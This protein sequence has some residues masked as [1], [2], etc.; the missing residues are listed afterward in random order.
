VVVSSWWLEAHWGRAFEL[1]RHEPLR[2][3]GLEGLGLDTHELVLGRPRPEQLTVADLEREEPDEPREQRARVREVEDARDE[4]RAT[5]ARLEDLEGRHGRLVEMW[6]AAVAHGERLADEGVEREER[7]AYLEARVAELERRGGPD[8]SARA[9]VE[10]ERL[11]ARRQEKGERERELQELREEL[12]EHQSELAR[13][14]DALDVVRAS[15][16]WRLTAPLRARAA[17][18]R[19]R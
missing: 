4:L 11:A 8:R 14:R 6:E 9:A 2:G 10:A 5:A 13:L 3:A 1:L 17:A 16:S 18:I 12:R 19:G 7:L 15:K